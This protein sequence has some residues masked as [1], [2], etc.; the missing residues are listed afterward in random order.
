MGKVFIHVGGRTI[1]ASGFEEIK[2]PRANNGQFG[3]G[4]GSKSSIGAGRG[5]GNNPGR[6]HKP[7]WKG[8]VVKTYPVGSRVRLGSSQEFH[9]VVGHSGAGQSAVLLLKGGGH[10]PAN[11]ALIKGDTDATKDGDE[12]GSC[13]CKGLKAAIPAT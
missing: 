6:A 1:D 4:G 10:M 11:R 8:T 12:P 2:H 3:S 13:G 5:P 7:E 9:E